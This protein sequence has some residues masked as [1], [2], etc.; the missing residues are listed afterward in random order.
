MDEATS[1]KPSKT[2]LDNTTSQPVENN[3]ILPEWFKEVL[4]R[5]QQNIT[6]EE[7]ITTQTQR[8]DA[9][10]VPKDLPLV[11]M[12]LHQ[13]KPPISDEKKEWFKKPVEAKAA[14]V[15]GSWFALLI[16]GQLGLIIAMDVNVYRRQIRRAIRTIRRWKRKRKIKNDEENKIKSE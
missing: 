15:V 3:K 12:I 10:R 1:G 9:R 14:E 5:K 2:D 13:A 7:E 6:K 8:P 16:A 11:A 4:Y